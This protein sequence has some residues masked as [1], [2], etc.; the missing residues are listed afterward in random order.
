MLGLQESMVVQLANTSIVNVTSHSFGIIATVDFNTPHCREVIENLMLVNDPLPAFRIQTFGTLEADQETVELQIMENTEETLIVEP[1][2][3]TAEAEV[4]KVILPLPPGL[5]A[6]S[7]IEVTFQLDR[8]GRLRVVGRE[9]TSETTVEATFE[10]RGGLSQEE[11]QR[12]KT[13]AGRVTIV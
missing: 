2:H 6:Y 5:P 9:P 4:G 7:P 13:R 8:Q 3:Y 11:L 12:V 10:T 1:T